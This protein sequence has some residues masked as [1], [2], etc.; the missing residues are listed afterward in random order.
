MENL[1]QVMTENVGVDGV[2]NL[3]LRF[4]VLFMEAAC[5]NG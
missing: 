3:I 4:L 5:L 2:N 1:W